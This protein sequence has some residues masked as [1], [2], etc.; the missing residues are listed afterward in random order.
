MLHGAARLKKQVSN[1]SDAQIVFEM[2]HLLTLLKQSHNAIDFDAQVER[3]KLTEL[4]LTFYI[5]PEGLYIVDAAAPYEDLIGAKVLRFDDTTAE[6]AIEATKYVI[7][8][9]NDMAVVW[10]A[11]KHLKLVQLLYALKLTS[12]PQ[13]ANLTVLDRDGKTRTVS[14]KPVVLSRPPKLKAPRLAN[15]PSPPLYLSRPEDIYWFEYLPDDKTIYLQYNQVEDKKDENLRQFGLRLRDFLV[16]N[17]VRNLIVDV[18]RNNGGSTFLD[19]ELLRTL[20]EFDTNKDNTLYLFT[21]R[22]T[23]SAASNFIT[24]V[25]RL[26]RAVIV[27]EPSSS[28]PL[29]TGGDEALIVLPYSGFLGFISSTTWAL[30]APRDTRLWIAPDIPVQLTAKD[31]FANRDPLLETVLKLIHEV[32]K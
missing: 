11:P 21:G 23:F 10:S 22:N 19:S 28:T 15:L 3:V 30:T 4:P 13:Q 32:K 29:M 6:R 17:E 31:Y 18:R 1:L 12:S 8:R 26:T 14:P 25:N 9:E 5:F 27:G 7:A 2:Q 24:D 20:I 16:K